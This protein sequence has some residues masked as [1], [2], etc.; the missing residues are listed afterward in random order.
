VIEGAF[1]VV[2]GFERIDDSREAMRS[3]ALTEPQQQAFARAAIAL[4]FDAGALRI[5]PLDGRRAR[6]LGLPLPPGPV[7]AIEPE[8]LAGTLDPQRGDLRLRQVAAIGP[9]HPEQVDGAEDALDRRQHRP[10]LD[11]DAVMEARAFAD[12]EGPDA[13]ARFRLPVGEQ[14]R[15]HAPASRS[16]REA[17]RGAARRGSFT[18]GVWM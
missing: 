17:T 9:F 1:R 14:R 3:T 7:I 11:R 2:D 8:E 12:V 4:R 16:S 5:P 18:A 13:P 6:L 15:R 10:G